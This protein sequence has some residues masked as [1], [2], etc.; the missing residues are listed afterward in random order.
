MEIDAGWF[1]SEID[2]VGRPPALADEPGHDARGS[3]LREYVRKIGRTIAASL[4]LISQLAA[5]TAYGQNQAIQAEIKSA[6]Q[7][8]R[9]GGQFLVSVS[10]KNPSAEEQSLQIWSCSFTKNWLPDNPIV[11]IPD[12][13][14]KKNSAIWVKLRPG[15]S[16][17]DRLAI[18]FVLGPGHGAREPV[19]FRLGFQPINFQG[20][21]GVSFPV[22][23]NTIT[24]NVIE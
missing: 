20:S 10:F 11:Q 22:W 19:A 3:G 13:P 23:S 4:T 15:E 16:H 6:L 1:A 17:Q 12:V 7:V 18:K 5:A 2:K 9:N 24:I 8:V 21:A 14:C